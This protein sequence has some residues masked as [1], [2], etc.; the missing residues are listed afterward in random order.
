MDEHYS[1]KKKKQERGHVN[2]RLTSGDVDSYIYS[3]LP[4]HVQVDLRSR[5][6]LGHCIQVKHHVVLGFLLIRNLDGARVL[7]VHDLTLQ[8]N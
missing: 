5:L 1:S 4:V 3:C 7:A 2:V 6:V 8:I